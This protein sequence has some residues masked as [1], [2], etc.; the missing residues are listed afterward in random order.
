MHLSKRLFCEHPL[1]WVL[2]HRDGV[3][4]GSGLYTALG[5]PF[6]TTHVGAAFAL[7][8]LRVAQG[9]RRCDHTTP[10]GAGTPQT[11]NLELFHVL[12][13]TSFYHGVGAFKSTRLRPFA[14]PHSNAAGAVL[15]TLEPRACQTC[16]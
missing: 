10:G 14:L 4:R 11:T 16:T 1:G 8:P 9:R 6:V 3:L 13:A 12:G 5:H 2:A 15:C 7:G